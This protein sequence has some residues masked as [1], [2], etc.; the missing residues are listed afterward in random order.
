MS[1]KSGSARAADET[2]DPSEL[3]SALSE[4]R[5]QI[6]NEVK[7]RRDVIKPLELVLRALKDP[8]RSAV[9][10]HEATTVLEQPPAELPL[11]KDFGRLVGQLRQL[12]DAKLSE[13]E[14]TFARDLR[15][16][17]AEQG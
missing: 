9:I 1:N 16:S 11:P 3:S 7:L 15:A 6:A 12:A 5:R 14:F 2:T 17:F 4:I 13:L 10:L 8:H